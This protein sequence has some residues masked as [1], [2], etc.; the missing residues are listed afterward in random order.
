MLENIQKIVI[1]KP[2]LI[3]IIIISIMFTSLGV[4]MGEAYAFDLNDDVET[5]LELNIGDKL[6]NSHEIETLQEN[7]YS[8]NGGTFRDIQDVVN[9]ASNGDTIELSGKYVA[10]D[11]NDSVIINKKLIFTSADKATLDAK[12]LTNIFKIYAGGAQSEFINLKFINGYT[13]DKGGAIRINA[14]NITLNNCVFENNHAEGGSGAVYTSYLPQVA[15]GLTV[16]NCNFTKN[17]AGTSAGALGAFGQHFKIINCVFDSNSVYND[18]ACY[19]GAIQIGLDTNVSYGIVVNSTFINNKAQSSKSISHGGAGCVRNGSSYYNC[20]FINNS[21]DFGGALTYHASGNLN[22]CTLINNTARDYGGAVAIWLNHDYMDLN[23]TNSRFIGN[24]APLGG[25]VKLDGFNIKI[26]N[27]T[28]EDNFAS[29]YGG[30]V[31]IE[32]YDVKI[33]NST[34][35][36]NIA[37]VDGGAVYIKGNDTTVKNSLFVS[38]EAIPDVKKLNDGLGGAIYINST[39]A[40]AQNNVFKLNTARNGSALYFD[41]H[42]VEFKLINNT[43]YQ[44]QAWVYAL[45]IQAQD[46]Y[47]GDSERIKSVIYGGNNIADYDN[48]AVSNAIY[49]AADHDKIE[50]DGEHPVSGATNSGKLYQDDRE[51][52][53]EIIMTVKHEDGTVVYNKALNSSYLGQVSLNLDNLKPGKYYVTAKHNE[54]NYYKGITNATTFN[55][56]PKT[57][58]RIIKLCNKDRITYGDVVIWTLEVTNDGPN[59]ATGVKVYDVLPEGLVWQKDNTN[60]KYN[61]E[62]GVLD[63]G[64]LNAGEMVAFKIT[65]LVNKTGKIN[66]KVNV[67][68]N[69]FDTNIE[70][71]YDQYQINVPNAIDLEVV[72]KANKSNP[73]FG[74]LVTWSIVVLNNGPDIAH[75]VEVRDMLAK[76]LIF[77]NATGNYDVKTGTWLIK[78]L[79]VGKSVKMTL[80]CR[81]NKTGVIK[82][83]ANV[84]ANEY[85]WNL[86]NNFD[87]KAINVAPASDL[88]VTKLVNDSNPNFGD[89][90]T[91]SVVVLNNGPD[92]AHNIKVADILPESLVF[93]NASG[94][95]NVKTNSWLIYSLGVGKS[96]KLTLL[97]RVN[98]TGEIRNAVNVSANE[99][100]WDLS[101]NF[102]DEVIDV[103]PASDLEVVKSI[104][105]SNPN[106]GDLVT[107][108]VVVLNNG[109]DV[110]HD[111]HVQDMLPESLIFVNATGHYDVKTSSWLINSLGVGKSVRLTLVCR[112]NRTGE[113]RNAVNV[114]ANEY[115]WDLSNN[116]DDEVIDVAPASDLRVTKL[117]N[118]SNPNFGDLVTWSV[119]VLNN[120]PD[121][122]HDIQ[123]I[124]M[125]PKSLI[126]V[127]ASGHYNVKSSSWIIKSLG[128]GKSVRL[129]LVCRVNKTGEITNMVNATAKEFD[130]DMTNNHDKNQIKVPRTV[131][132]NVIK[133]ANVTNPNYLD[134]VNWTIEVSNFGPDAAH[135]IKV[136]DELPDSLTFVDASSNYDKETG[137]WNI[138]SLGVNETIKLYIVCRVNATGEIINGVNVTSRER[139]YNE[140]DNFDEKTIDVAPAC[141]LAIVKMVND[142]NPNYHDLVTWTIEVS[143]SGPDIAHDIEV[144]ELLPE[145]LI[146]ISDD[147]LGKYN[148]N[149][150]IW[151]IHSLNRGESV[152]LNLISFVNCTGNITNIVSVTSKEYDYNPENNN[153][154]NII[155]VNKSGDL[156]I[157]KNVNASG[158]NYDDLIR[159]I[160]TVSNKGPDKVT[161]IIV[162]DVLPEGLVLVDYDASK[163]FYDEGL[164]NLCCLEKGEIQT[165]EIICRVNITGNITNIAKISGKEYDSNLTNNVDNE[166]VEIPFAADIQ[167]IKQV[168]NKSPFFGDV[169]VWM[170]KVENKGPDTAT[171]IQIFDELPESL[172]FM[173][174]QSTNG[175]YRNGIWNID[176]L[177]TGNSEYLNISCRVNELGVIIN[178]AT[179]TANEYDTDMSNNHDD[180]FI[181]AFPV[182]DLS[183]Q[184]IANVSDANYG[185]FV[186]W[187]LIVSN[188]G[189][190]DATGVFVEDILPNSLEYVE[191]Y[192]DGEYGDGVWYIGDVEVGESKKLNIVSKIIKTG[193]IVNSA[194]VYG[195][196]KDPD[197]SNNEAEESIYIPPAADLSISKTVSKSE[198]NVGDLIEFSIRLINNGPDR[199]LNVKVKEIFDDFLHLKSFKA[200]K[201]SFDKMSSEWNIDELES[202]SEE[203]LLIVFEAIK[204]GEFENIASVISDTFD[205]DRNNNEDG[206]FVKIVENITNG[207][208]KTLSIEDDLLKS[209][210]IDSPLSNLQ[211]HPT[212]NPILL[213]VGSLLISMMFVG[214]NIFKKR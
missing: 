155:R 86:S 73:N 174:Y 44:N 210:N 62:T 76:S 184:K 56:I 21:A 34:F 189:F 140:S 192:G 114:S 8:L 196:Q 162:E 78:S 80:V 181:D 65:T 126:F 145:S 52:N 60:G 185:D 118:D 144:V 58:L 42:G 85:D 39:K 203:N 180:A 1:S 211:K 111:I 188:E 183:I 61:P 98:K 143:N 18:L 156:S 129:T 212:S 172:I 127:N 165:L 55:V 87:E 63:I 119:V 117:V 187:T 68:G 214:G 41:K 204:E 197:L 29:K 84:S 110:A 141:D 201:G 40:L 103:A 13:D 142:S 115:D 139:D 24:K 195:N 134:L 190:N 136:I 96:A 164:W 147:S 45:P 148:P 173:D 152:R 47:Y 67:S 57:D 159:W 27:S 15:E 199:A 16:K 83:S 206:A 32:A 169:V 97:C 28:F 70:N 163:G 200:S 112:I 7:T 198:Y 167:V 79:G 2:F 207:T 128:V 22:N 72:K 74:D 107:W 176:H 186:R 150:G 20:I 14:K 166:T 38:N 94:Y 154:S 193:S 77:V 54:D 35:R 125:L 194:I 89:L 179:A 100:D 122:A 101:N 91:W 160:L 99:Y 90:V 130:P 202:G 64:S 11:E 161:D 88:R 12:N 108:G 116:F 120:G 104:N 105:K 109:P 71:N 6:E 92:V 93:V 124:D 121:I 146:W 131:D 26:V 49:N 133:K 149:N 178:D 48:L 153:D 31:N 30:A 4:N 10:S 5:G 25:A 17:T 123:V 151:N 191:A 171:N 138:K 36:K 158:A 53:I 23:I 81:V 113:I 50:I 209:R 37:N 182:S 168:D 51:Y 95:Y 137:I 82:N 102:D 205:F 19:G 135:D 69:E 3:S 132:L 208:D 157:V 75:D 9:S 46:I 170:I 175:V 59:N 66:N 106:F 33:L 213:L 43:L 177:N